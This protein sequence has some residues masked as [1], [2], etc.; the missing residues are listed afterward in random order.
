MLLVFCREFLFIS[1]PVI[2]CFMMVVFG[3]SGKKKKKSE[4]WGMQKA[5]SPGELTLWEA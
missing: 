1:Y 2:N 5:V 3:T 4:D